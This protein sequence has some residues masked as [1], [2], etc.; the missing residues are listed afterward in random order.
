MNTIEV[1]I[2]P[3]Q[4]EDTEAIHAL[5]VAA[6]GR[7]NESQLIE[8]LRKS[9]AFIPK[10]SLVA[11]LDHEIAGHILFTKINIMGNNDQEYP[12]L[13]LA[14]MAVA[15]DFQHQGIG[16]Q[17]ISQGLEKAKA[18]AYTSVIVLGHEKYYPRFGFVPTSQWNIVPPFEVPASAFMGIEL[19]AG[20]LQ[21]ISGTVRYPK[22]FEMV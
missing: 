19:Q 13:A 5:N 14:P 15:P 2:R 21:D 1:L 7:E 3:E 9:D 6:F 12:S 4:A 18:L 22:E 10:L 17:L 8:L 16:S 11:V 20:A